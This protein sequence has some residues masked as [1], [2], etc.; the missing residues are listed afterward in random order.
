M[1][2]TVAMAAVHPMGVTF[3]FVYCFLLF[4]TQFG[5]TLRVGS[6]EYSGI[7]EFSQCIHCFL[8][9]VSEVGMGGGGH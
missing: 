4:P 2:M 8:Q 6:N 9:R 7:C 5:F 3:R 1:M